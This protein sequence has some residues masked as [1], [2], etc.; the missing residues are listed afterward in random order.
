MN[1][2]GRKR[3]NCVF[4][5]RSS[6]QVRVL[7]G[8]KYASESGRQSSHKQRQDINVVHRD[9]QWH[10]LNMKREKMGKD[11]SLL[12]PSWGGCTVCLGRPRSNLLLHLHGTPHTSLIE[13][14]LG[15]RVTLGLNSG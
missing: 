11:D 7:R 13:V 12:W 9:A 14:R 3:E 6:R 15:L 2:L 4:F 8:Q 10:W 1:I 5:P